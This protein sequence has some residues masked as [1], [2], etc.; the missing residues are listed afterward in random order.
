[1]MPISNI[2]DPQ[3]QFSKEH[4]KGKSVCSD[5]LEDTLLQ[6]WDEPRSFPGSSPLP[7]EQA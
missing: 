6:G 3:K 2:F 5:S 4:K 7:L 1:M